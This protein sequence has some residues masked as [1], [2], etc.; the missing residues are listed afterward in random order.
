M[1]NNLALQQLTT[2]QTNKEGGVNTA[3][4]Q[5]DAAITEITNID[6]TSGNATP[7][8][9]AVRGAFKFVAQNAT[10]PGRQVTFAAVKRGLVVLEADTSCTQSV[11]FK[12]GTSTITVGPGTVQLAYMDGTTNGLRTAFTAI[13]SLSTLSDVTVTSVADK[14]ELRYDA[15]SGRWVNVDRSTVVIKTADYTLAMT[16]YN[17]VVQMNKA[18]AI[19]LTVPPNGTVAFPIGTEIEVHS[20]GAGATTIVA[21]AGVSINTVSGLTSASTNQR[22]LLR[23]VGSNL[24]HFDWLGAGGAGGSLAGLSDVAI[25]SPTNNQVLTY[26]TATSKWKNAAAGS[27][28]RMREVSYRPPKT[29]DFATSVDL[30]S[31]GTPTWTD[32][33]DVNKPTVYG[34]PSGYFNNGTDRH[35]NR[36]KSAPSGKTVKIRMKL[37]GPLWNFGGGGICMRNSATGRYTWWGLNY[38]G[39]L[40][41]TLI[42]WAAGTFNASHFTLTLNQTPSYDCEWFMVDWSDNTNI[43]CYISH[44]GENWN[45]LTQVTLAAFQTA[46]DQVGFA[47]FVNGQT[48]N[49]NVNAKG[50]QLQLYYYSDS[51]I[52]S[53]D[54]S[55]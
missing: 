19:N 16:E 4:G 54:T 53:A 8:A 49:W 43:K 52:N 15:G 24:W 6:L 51:N 12:V 11:A 17:G 3:T 5:L 44:D 48:F 38:N 26:D 29:A 28:V 1:S 10:T 45:F 23:K 9:A 37:R 33:N 41:H 46:I 14:Q 27:S 31:P 30:N 2:G 36:L 39:G 35:S 47:I 13:T 34:L 18:T 40:F 21:G 55:L 22:G 32:G 42:S 20:I 25:S 7:N 50:P